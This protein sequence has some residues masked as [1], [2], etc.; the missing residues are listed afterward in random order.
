VPAHR[1]P[2]FVIIGAMKAGTTTL[3]EQ[4]ALQTGVFMP[5]MKELD[6]FIAERNWRRGL[7]WY[8]AQ[9]AAAPEQAILGEASPNYTKAASFKGVPERLHELIPNAKLIYLLRD[10][11]ARMRSQYAHS[12]LSGRERQSPEA[13]ITE[14]SGYLDTSLYGAQ[15]VL[16]RRLFPE[17]QILVVLTEEMRDDP[18]GFLER[19]QGFLGLPTIEVPD[20]TRRANVTAERRGYGPIAATLRRRGRPVLDLARRVLPDSW[21]DFMQ[22]RMS[23]D[24]PP[25]RLTVPD[26]VIERLSGYLADDRKL[27]L[28]QCEGLDLSKWP[29]IE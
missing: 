17:E 1:F 20:P 6:F 3:F 16:Y 5:A 11:V 12:V 26:P 18:T 27:L 2:D 29:V 13:A 7:D 4:L 22:T 14:T 10:P 15:L 19:V 28:S 21:Y 24:V 25:E 23:L 8:A 9:F